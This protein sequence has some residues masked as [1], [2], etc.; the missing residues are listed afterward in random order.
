VP[1]HFLLHFLTS[2]RVDLPDAITT[3]RCYSL[4]SDISISVPTDLIFTSSTVDF[5]GGGQCGKLMFSEK[6]WGRCCNRFTLN[7]KFLTERYC[8]LSN[9]PLFRLH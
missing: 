5:K 9:V 6:L 2:N 7:M 4:F 1:P 3:Q 8:S